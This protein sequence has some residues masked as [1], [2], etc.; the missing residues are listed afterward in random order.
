MGLLPEY[1]LKTELYGLLR[2]FFLLPFVPIED[3]KLA[4]LECR[5]ELS[6]LKITLA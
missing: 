3:L 4:F 5:R 6:N 2:P 1:M